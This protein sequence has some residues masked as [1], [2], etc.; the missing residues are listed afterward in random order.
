[1]KNKV[2][3]LATGLFLVTA[4]LVG[5]INANGTEFN[6]LK[7]EI[8]ETPAQMENWMTDDAIWNTESFNDELFIVEAE[9]ELEIENWM[10][11][12][13]IWN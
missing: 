10:T 4:L 13:S 6:A 9:T 1:M 3:Q 7:N 12:E 5:N 2:T 11:S 8:I